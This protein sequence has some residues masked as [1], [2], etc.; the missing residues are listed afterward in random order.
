MYRST[1]PTTLT[2]MALVCLLV[3][4]VTLPVTLLLGRAIARRSAWER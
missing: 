4:A 3:L 1:N 2:T